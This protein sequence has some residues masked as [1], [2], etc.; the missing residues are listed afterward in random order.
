MPEGD[1]DKLSVL[2]QCDTEWHAESLAAGLRGRGIAAQA[3][4]GY[5]AGWRAES[6]A[7]A[8]VM[9]FKKDLLPARLLLSELKTEAGSIDWDTVDV[10]E[11][12]EG[13]PEPVGKIGPGPTNNDAKEAAAGRT[14]GLLLTIVLI[15][16]AVAVLAIA[17][18]C[19]GVTRGY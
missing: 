4:G 15:V 5:V 13:V 1:A 6:P 18:A 12:I 9:V 16:G 8:R 3:E 19:A 14:K 2:V 10:G 17:K 7:K 11:N